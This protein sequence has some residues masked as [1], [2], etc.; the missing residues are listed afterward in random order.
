MKITLVCSC[1]LF[2]EAQG[3]KLL[4]DGLNSPLAPFYE[5]PQ[6]D[7]EAVLRGEAPYDGALALGFTHTHADHFCR[8]KLQRVLAARKD[9]TVFVPD[10]CAP[11]QGRVKFGAFTVEFYKFAHTPVPENLRCEHYVLL[12]EA[13]GKRVYVTAD[14]APEP[15]RHREILAGRRCDAAFWNGQYLSHLET[16]ALLREAAG[17][18]YVYHIP[19]DPMDVS[20]ICRKCERNMERFQKELERVTLLE[21]YPSEIEL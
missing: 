7:F 5:L 13:E 18:N 20:G 19:L 14:A 1:G 16:R 8:D 10:A 9:V 2:I 6:A 21:T 15:E 11:E 17:K 3:S 4:I 12:I